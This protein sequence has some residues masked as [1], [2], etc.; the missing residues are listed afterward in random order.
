MSDDDIRESRETLLQDIEKKLRF[1]DEQL[2]FGQ[3]VWGVINIAWVSLCI[4]GLGH[5]LAGLTD[6][7]QLYNVA[8]LLF[9]TEE[10]F[11]CF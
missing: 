7:I 6:T 2:R 8:H 11:C 4:V 1:K 10:R 3:Q 5:A 9:F